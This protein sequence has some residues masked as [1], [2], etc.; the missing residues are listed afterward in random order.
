MVSSQ[1]IR[2]ARALLGISATELAERST[3]SHRTL[4]RFETQ[5]G[6]P[7]SRSGNLESIERA[8]TELGILF[9]GDPLTSPGVQLRTMDAA[10]IEDKPNA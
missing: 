6:I 4:Q 9:T 8:L 5:D 7:E 3:V 2:A 1:Q 10:D